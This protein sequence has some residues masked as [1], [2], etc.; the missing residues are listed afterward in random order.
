MSKLV[1]DSLVMNR[2]YLQYQIGISIIRDIMKR[3]TFMNVSY[4]IAIDQIQR[5]L[6]KSQTLPKVLG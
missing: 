3:I 6:K 4:G 1:W 5:V 2:A